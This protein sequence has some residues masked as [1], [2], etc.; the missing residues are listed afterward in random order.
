MTPCRPSG[1]LARAVGDDDVVA[2][3]GEGPGD[4]QADAP[5]ASGHEHV[6]GVSHRVPPVVRWAEVRAPGTLADYRW[7]CRIRIG[8]LWRSE[9]APARP[10][11][12][13][14]LRHERPPVAAGRPELPDAPL[15]ALDGHAHRLL[16]PGGAVPRRP[17]LDDRRL[18]DGGRR[19][20]AALRGRGDGQR[21]PLPLQQRARAPAATVPPGDRG[22]R[23]GS[24][25]RRRAAPAPEGTR[26]T[27]GQRHGRRVRAATATARNGREP[28][29]PPRRRRAVPT[30][31]D[32]QRE[33]L[34]RGR[35][36]RAP[37]EQ[38]P[39]HTPDRRKTWLAC[40]AHRESLGAFLS[41]RGFLRDTVP[42][43]E[44]DERD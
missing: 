44:L 37:V 21:L 27:L 6:A 26:R 13:G 15:P 22:P 5:V 9:K 17:A 34:P 16:P 31:T 39:L 4:G 38:P 19:G 20:G 3:L 12:A 10:R 7:V 24:P 36:V 23:R 33:G 18:G 2:G 8:L 41:V 43:R 40:E 35:G 1:R 25:P 14:V 28:R 29:R 42:V 32:L 30:P 11:A